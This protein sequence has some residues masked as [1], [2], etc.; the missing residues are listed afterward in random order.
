MSGRAERA[1]GGA[2]GVS[3]SLWLQSPQQAPNVDGGDHCRLWSLPLTSWLTSYPMGS[4]HWLPRGVILDQLPPLLLSRFSPME[5][6][7]HWQ[8]IDHSVRA[9]ACVPLCWEHLVHRWFAP[10]Y[11]TVSPAEG[12]G[13]VGFLGRTRACWRVGCFSQSMRQLWTGTRKCPRQSPVTVTTPN[14]APVPWEN[15][16]S[17]PEWAFPSTDL[18][19]P[20]LAESLGD[21]ALADTERSLSSLGHTLGGRPP[22]E[23]ASPLRSCRPLCGQAGAP[24]SPA[25]PHPSRSALYPPPPRCAE[26][27][28]VPSSPHTVALVP[29]SICTTHGSPRLSQ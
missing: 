27:G 6:E 12:T 17:R 3:W 23:W 15:S 22:A 20:L 19:N 28:S 24:A 9:S 1:L 14:R 29:E 21:R 25:R 7:P 13:Q 10:G 5:R 16:V 18:I 2:G 26:A 4:S 11:L 8:F